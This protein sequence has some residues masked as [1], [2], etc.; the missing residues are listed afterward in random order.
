MNTSKQKISQKS[1]TIANN[2]NFFQ[3][4]SLAE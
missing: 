2:I 4:N 1:G 3:L